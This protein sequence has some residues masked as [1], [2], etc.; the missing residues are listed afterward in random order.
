VVE[1]QPVE[2]TLGRLTS[3]IELSGSAAAA[4]SD[5]LSFRTAGTIASVDVEVGERVTAGQLLARLD[6]AGAQRGV[7]LAEIALRQAELRLAEL[8]AD[9]TAAEIASAQQSTASARAQLA[10]AEQALATLTGVPEAR[11]SS[12]RRASRWTRCCRGRR[13]PRSLRPTRRS[14]RQSRSSLRP[15]IR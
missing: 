12:P 11:R 2:A 9:A 6:D 8:A 13:T 1:P 15:R 3:T 5:D 14:Y 7:E 10:A 4:L